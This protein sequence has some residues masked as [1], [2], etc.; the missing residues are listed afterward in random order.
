MSSPNAFWDA[1]A[2]IPLFIH[3]IVSAQAHTLFRQ[4][5]PVVWWGTA[6]EVES[7]FARL[8]R[9]NGLNDQDWQVALGYLVTL[10]QSW[11][12]IEPSSNLRDLAGTLMYRFP[13]RAADALQLAAA[14]RWCQ[15]RPAGRTFISGDIR[16]CEAAELAGFTVIR[17]GIATA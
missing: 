15:Q 9:S 16:L 6:V 12:E 5:S 14:L 3:E 13:L 1:S 2:L 11:H 7:S 17:L 8:R 10:T 4:W